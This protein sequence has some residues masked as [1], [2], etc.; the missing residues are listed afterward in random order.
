MLDKD[1]DQ[2]FKSSL[3]DVEITPTQTSWTDISNRLD[4]K[5]HQKKF[6]FWMAAASVLLVFGIGIGLYH[7]TD[8]TIK[9]HPNEDR[10]M[11]A[12]LVQDEASVLKN[13][14]KQENS[15]VSLAEKKRIMIRKIAPTLG[16]ADADTTNDTSTANEALEPMSDNHEMTYTAVIQTVK[17]PKAKLVTE[18]ILHQEELAPL[19]KIRVINLE[20]DQSEIEL[21]SSSLEP[22]TKRLKIGSLGDIVNFVVAK[23]DKREEKIIRISKTEESD[24]EVTGINLGLFKFSKQ[25]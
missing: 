20:D 10:E 24:N 19:K 25:N 3:E 8:E 7:Q 12:N 23:V 16:H 9:L 15:S 13:T 6:P 22:N 4:A 14:P 18:Q 11:T 21:L 1:I 5:P 17:I 2:L